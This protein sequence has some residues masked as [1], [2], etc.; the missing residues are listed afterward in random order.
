MIGPG[1]VHRSG[2]KDLAVQAVIRN[3]PSTSHFPENKLLQIVYI[4]TA[5]MAVSQPVL[6]EILAV[7]RRNNEGAGVTGLLVAGG[8]RFLQALEGP[9]E[10]VLSTLARIRRDDRHYAVVE[11]VNRPV[12]QRAFGDWAMAFED[13]AAIGID[14]SL[15]DAVDGLTAGLN[16]PTLRAEFQGF[17]ALHAA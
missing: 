8:R 10:T 4:S 2:A 15:R 12:E 11:L 3:E 6:Q 16:D 14:A 7:S 1:A 5:R 13:A 9:A 17:A